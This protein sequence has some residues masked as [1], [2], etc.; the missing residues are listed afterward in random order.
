MDRAAIQITPAKD[1]KSDRDTA[2]DTVVG[3][4]GQQGAIRTTAR[5]IKSQ[6]LDVA[7]VVVA[8]ATQRRRNQVGTIENSDNLA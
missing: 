7:T 1:M 5:T 3:R 2:M 4:P 6:R 8:T